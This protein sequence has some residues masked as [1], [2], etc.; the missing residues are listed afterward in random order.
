MANKYYVTYKDKGR[1]R[2]QVFKTYG[3]ATKHATE[4]RSIPA[5]NGVTEVVIK[6]MTN[7][8][9]ETNG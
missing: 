6:T 1:F 4:L 8:G 5:G 3:E 2:C 9:V 7:R